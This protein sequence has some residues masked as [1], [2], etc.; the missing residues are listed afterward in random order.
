MLWPLLAA[1]VWSVAGVAPPVLAEGVFY[2]PDR[3]P[4][5]SP[6]YDG[7]HRIMIGF[8]C[9]SA[10]WYSKSARCGFRH[11]FHHGVDVNMPCGTKI[12][13]AVAGVVVSPS[14]AGRPGPAYGRHPLRIRAGR[15][16]FV[17]GH[18]QVL[19]VGTG[20]RIQPG[21]LIA[22]ASDDG[23]PDGCHLHLEVRPAGKGYAAAVNPFP[24]AG[25][26]R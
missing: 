18:A 16:D 26:R 7:K 19:Y 3:T 17:I 13:S 21:Q 20:Q 15:K 11:G 2:Y 8:G 9:T 25:F 5:A 4:Y 24:Y 14:A 10:P 1:I 6:W 23:A 12:R 22:R